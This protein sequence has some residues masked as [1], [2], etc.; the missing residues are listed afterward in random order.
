M[1]KYIN[2]E[3]IIK[4]EIYKLFEPLLICPL[5]QNIYINPI[6]CMKCQIAYCKI[7]VDK[8]KKKNNKKCPNNCE[9][10]EYNNCFSKYE[11]LK[12]LKFICSGC[13]KEIGYNE[14]EIHHISCCPDKTSAD[15]KLKMKKLMPEEVEKFRKEGLEIIYIISK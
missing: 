9:A 13:N 15:K 10:P 2:K 8:W 4:N 6:I 5:C 12:K 3:T 14:A 11:I 7:C 1:E